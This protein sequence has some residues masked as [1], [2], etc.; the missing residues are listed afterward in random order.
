M[1]LKAAKSVMSI[2]DKKMFKDVGVGSMLNIG[3]NG[4]FGYQT[5]RDSREQGMGRLGSTASAVADMVMADVVGM[6]AY[7]GAM[8]V[9]GLPK[10]AVSG[11]ENLTKMGRSMSMNSASNQPFKNAMFNDSNQAYTMRQAGMQLAKASKYNLQN[12]MLGQEAQYL[13]Y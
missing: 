4:Y 3:L 6:P 9:S 5:Y 2:M 8:A 10:A 12:S 7:L 11:Y 1:A 13:R